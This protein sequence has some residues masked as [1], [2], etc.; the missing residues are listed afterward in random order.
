VP[1]VVGRSDNYAELPWMAFAAGTSLAALG[2][3]AAD[4][5]RPHWTVAY[6][7]LVHATIILGAGATAALLAI[8]VPPF[9]RLFLRPAQIGA[10]VRQY[11]E[12]LFLR[13]QLFATTRR[14]GILI[15]VS[16]FERRIEIV[17]DEGC[18]NWIAQADW[19]AIIAGMAPRLRERRPGH[20]LLDA[21]AAV[22]SLLQSKGFEHRDGDTNDLPDAAIE[23]RG[24]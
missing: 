7:A 24:E 8:F 3:V 19:Q 21:L 15:L 18:R 13:H 6:T 10:E 16:L 12:S 14:T 23:E 2:L 17:A 9:A 11:A 4:T 1:A 5:L 20:A 22:D